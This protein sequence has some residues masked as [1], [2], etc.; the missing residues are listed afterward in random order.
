M[1]SQK[2]LQEQIYKYIDAPLNPGVNFDTGLYYESLGQTAAA[3]SFY[4]RCAELTDDDLLAYEALLKTYRCVA[5]QTR[6]SRDP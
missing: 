2:Q 3:L 6:R 4:L 5:E 1:V